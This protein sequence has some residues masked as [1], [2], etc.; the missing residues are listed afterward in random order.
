MAYCRVTRSKT[1]SL[2]GIFGWLRQEPCHSS[3]WCR[4]LWG[5]HQGTWHHTLARH[6]KTWGSKGMGPWHIPVR[7]CFWNSLKSGLTVAC[8]W[9]ISPATWK[10]DAKICWISPILADDWPHVDPC[11]FYS[12][13][14]KPLTIAT[15]AMRRDLLHQCTGVLLIERILSIV[16][17]RQPWTWADGLGVSQS[18]THIA[19]PQRPM[20]V[21]R[22]DAWILTLAKNCERVPGYPSFTD[23]RIASKSYQMTCLGHAA[24]IL[25]N[26]FRSHMLTQSCHIPA[27]MDCASTSPNPRWY[28]SAPQAWPILLHALFCCVA[29]RHQFHPSLIHCSWHLNVAAILQQQMNS[30]VPKSVPEKRPSES[31][32]GL[33]RLQD[34]L[35]NARDDESHGVVGRP[36]N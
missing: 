31:C 18:S 20:I 32:P 6:E 13:H 24:F 25:V 15:T 8:R 9:A 30:V 10:C 12:H 22:C 35:Q 17:W 33:A 26:K 3:E 1:H 16:I 4:W 36:R 11:R 5:C 29:K 2:P 23:C 34:L 28:R 21:I 7:W 19:A 14:S 27:K